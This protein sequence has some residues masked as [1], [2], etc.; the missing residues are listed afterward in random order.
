MK[1]SLKKIRLH[2][3]VF[4]KVELVEVGNID[5]FSKNTSQ[6][7]G[8]AVSHGLMTRVESLE[9]R[10]CRTVHNMATGERVCV[11]ACEQLWCVTVFAL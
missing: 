7:K 4:G 8:K 10:V 11:N 2:L 5:A 6:E 9:N 3:T 1:E